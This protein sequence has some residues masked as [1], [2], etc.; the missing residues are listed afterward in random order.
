MTAA[1]PTGD[2]EKV[3]FGGERAADSRSLVD[4]ID[5]L[6]AD[7]TTWLEAE[8]NYQKTW[9]SF[10]GSRFKRTIALGL[11]GGLLGLFAVIG[12][13]VGLIIAL[14]PLV[15]AWGATAIVVGVLM[16]AAWLAIRGASKAWADLTEAVG[17]GGSVS[18]EDI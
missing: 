3:T 14:T 1:D 12:L 5:D 2:E 16:I 6:L 15:T 13:V 4:D 17:E 18:P 8:V 11:V 10:I 7:A 9:A